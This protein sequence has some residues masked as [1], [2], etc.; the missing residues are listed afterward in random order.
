MKHKLFLTVAAIAAAVLLLK[1]EWIILN[2][3]YSSVTETKTSI[4]KTYCS[5]MQIVEAMPKTV[6][7]ETAEETRKA[8]VAD[9]VSVWDIV[10]VYVDSPEELAKWCT[11]TEF[12]PYLEDADSVYI[13]MLASSRKTTY[14]LRRK[15]ME[16]SRTGTS[17]PRTAWGKFLQK[18]T[19]AIGSEKESFATL[20]YENGIVIKAVSKYFFFHKMT[21]KSIPK[22]WSKK[23]VIAVKDAQGYWL[24]AMVDGEGTLS[25]LSEWGEIAS[26]AK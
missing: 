13:G 1:A 18:E 17:S 22:V 26:I 4:N 19:E 20:M 9:A 7:D 12:S 8:Y 24:P 16:T 3:Y 2:W 25:L 11:E 14:E 21:L 10:E 6:I 23:K 15:A 5:P